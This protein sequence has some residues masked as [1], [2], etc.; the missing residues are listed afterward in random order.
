VMKRIRNVE[1]CVEYILLKRHPNPMLDPKKDPK[2]Y[3]A[4]AKLAKK[5]RMLE[6]E[7][8]MQQSSF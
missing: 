1:K 5:K 6:L 4:K 8:F 2:G 3:I 7:R